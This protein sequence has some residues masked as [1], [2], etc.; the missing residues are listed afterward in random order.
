MLHVHKVSVF[1]FLWMIGKVFILCLLIRFFYGTLF[2][3]Q[4]YALVEEETRRYRPTKNYLEHLPALD[5]T[6][7]ET[8][9][10]KAEF[11]RMANRLPMDMLS[12]KR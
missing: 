6:P 8:E 11:D 3:L 12:M 4:A 9:V 10:L 1:G 2:I 5:H 7:F